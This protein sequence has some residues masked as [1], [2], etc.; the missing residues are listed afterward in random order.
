VLAR[1]VAEVDGVQAQVPHVPAA[2]GAGF[3]YLEAEDADTPAEETRVHSRADFGDDSGDL[4]AG[5]DIVGIGPDLARGMLRP[6]VLAM[7]VADIAAAD[8]PVG[9]HD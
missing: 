6:G 9:H 4:A 3:V 1:A 5:D 7:E 2:P 8:A